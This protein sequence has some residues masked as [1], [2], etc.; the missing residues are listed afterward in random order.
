MDSYGYLTLGGGT[1]FRLF[2]MIQ[3]WSRDALYRRESIYKTMVWSVNDWTSTDGLSL[4]SKHV[5]KDLSTK[6]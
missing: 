2:D 1:E 4:P 5:V 3:M 6:N